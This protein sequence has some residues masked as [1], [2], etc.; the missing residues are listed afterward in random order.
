MISMRLVAASTITPLSS[1]IPS[2]SVKN[3]LMTRSVTWESALA[4][5][6]GAIESISSKK[7]MQG[8]ACFAFLKISLMPL[9]YSPIHLESKAGPL[10]EM[11]FTSLSLA[12]ALARRVLPVP[13][14]PWRRSP[15][16]G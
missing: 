11:K 7:T 6:M 3:W 16:G 1:S 13:G 2:S 5:R 8:L 15:L 14:G 4:P 9:S 12:T 10:T